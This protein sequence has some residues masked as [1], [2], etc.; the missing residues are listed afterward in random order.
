MGPNG[1]GKTTLLRFVAL[2]SRS[3]HLPGQDVSFGAI[4]REGHGSADDIAYLP[5]FVTDVGDVTLSGLLSVAFSKSR[6]S[7]RVQH[8]VET[9]NL[10]RPLFSLSGGE[11]QLLLFLVTAAQPQ[12]V[13]VYDEPFRH[14]DRRSR[15]TVAEVL[16]GLVDEG[17]LVIIAA[18]EDE[19]V[20]VR[21]MPLHVTRL[22]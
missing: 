8:F 9:K 4:R 17:K 20:A 18:H 1:I 21:S 2:R 11:R 15:N 16:C 5:Q 10:G 7:D 6:P 12:L 22:I 14:L 19:L 13:H 3:D